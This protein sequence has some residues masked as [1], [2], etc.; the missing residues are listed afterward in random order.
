[1]EKG[2]DRTPKVSKSAARALRKSQKE[3]R[4]NFTPLATEQ[5][6]RE[7]LIDEPAKN[8]RRIAE[9]N[10]IYNAKVEYCPITKADKE[11]QW[12]W[13][14]SRDWGD[15]IWLSDIKPYLDEFSRST[16]G[17]ILNQKAPGNK[18]KGR[19]RHHDMAVDELV[20][21]A[22][23]RWL[24]LDNLNLFERTFRFRLAS[25]KRLW[26]IRILSKF[27]LVWWDPKHKIYPL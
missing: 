27:Y 22:I 13:G 25:R 11:G 17:E 18:G 26:G 4:R 16:W 10:S 21:E 24:L 2:K 9:P 3:A 20:D 5:P 7:V 19:L 6:R 8:P 15:E 12:S 1:M 23:E 14:Q